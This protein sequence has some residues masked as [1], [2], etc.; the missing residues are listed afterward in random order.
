MAEDKSDQSQNLVSP[1][2]KVSAP[3]RR[4]SLFLFLRERTLG[5]FLSLN[6]PAGVCRWRNEKCKCRGVFT[7]NFQPEAQ[8][9]CTSL[10]C[11]PHCASRRDFLLI[12]GKR[13]GNT[14]AVRRKFDAFIIVFIV[15]HVYHNGVKPESKFTNFANLCLF[16]HS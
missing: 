12:I 1:Q 5:D 15:K 16:V 4:N 14:A 9:K 8:I 7:A 11:T 13:P 6:E 3:R 10:Q 2:R